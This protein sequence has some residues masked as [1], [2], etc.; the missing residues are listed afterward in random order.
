[1]LSFYFPLGKVAS[2]VFLVVGLPHKVEI[3]SNSFNLCLSQQGLLVEG[4]R[5]INSQVT[6]I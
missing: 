3:I 5:Y 4:S 2:G 6:H 1:V